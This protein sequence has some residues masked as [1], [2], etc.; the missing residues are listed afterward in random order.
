MSY[1]KVVD[2]GVDAAVMLLVI[3]ANPSTYL[4]VPTMAYSRLDR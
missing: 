2:D 3:V 1:P 4:R